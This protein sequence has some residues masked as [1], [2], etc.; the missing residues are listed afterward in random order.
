MARPER[1]HPK[2]MPARQPPKRESKM[3]QIIRQLQI[4]PIV[5]IACERASVPR[6]TYY[7]WRTNDFVFARAADKA[8]EASRVLLNDLAESQLSRAD[9]N[10][11]PWAIRYWLPH[12]HPRYARK[13]IPE[14][15]DIRETKSTEEKQ[16]EDRRTKRNYEITPVAMREQ[17][18]GDIDDRHERKAYDE[19]DAMFERFE[20][21]KDE[22]DEDESPDKPG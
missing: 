3:R 19:E 4:T 1:I 16:R 22:S 18:V 6:Q 12:N 15:S 20:M 2:D 21:L 11:E 10:G 5:Q 7:R 14:H 13:E 8:M 17:L 9:K